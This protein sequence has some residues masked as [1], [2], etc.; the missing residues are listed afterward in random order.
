M[1]RVMRAEYAR[2]PIFMMWMGLL[3]VFLV[4]GL[5][6]GASVLLNGLGVTN[7]TDNVPWGLWITIDLSSIAMGAGAFSLSALVYIFRIERLRPI[8]RI[9]VFTGLIGYTGAMLALF[10]DIGRPERFWH[11]TV[12]WNVHSVLWEITMCVL[13]Y[14]SVLLFEFAPI[15]F[16][17]KPM[18]RIFPSGPR[19]G[20]FIHRFAPIAA[21]IGLGLSMLHQSSLGA[22][23]GVLVARPIWFKP[24]LP[25]MFI[26]SAVAAGTT[27]VLG[28]TVLYENLIRQ[29]QITRPVRNALGV[30]AGL[31]LAAYL[32][33]T[34]W[35]YLATNYY[36]HLPARIESIE[37]LN[38]FAPYGTSFWLVEVFLGALVP[39]IILLTPR[40]RRRDALVMLAAVL[41]LTGVVVNRWNV[42]L[43]GLIVPMDWSPGAA[44]VFSVNAYRPSW[45]EW[46][47]GLGV[48]GYVLLAF[49][50]GL[51]YLPIYADEH[52]EENPD[53]E[54]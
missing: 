33:L 38:R 46:G 17:S 13:L 24:S 4:V 47:V 11:P 5:I 48:V 22:T 53:T 41:A 15:L 1:I 9:A 29:R 10:M 45:I 23:Y 49:T 50:L 51:R 28:I 36:S 44:S 54:I 20:H 19:I 32:Y 40:L 27:V 2:S 25:V 42:T 8:A 7:L 31:M 34:L 43:S 39:I 35:D 12:Y 3:G 14:S 37:L 6:S 52:H 16:E 30:F 26:L 18:R 21:I